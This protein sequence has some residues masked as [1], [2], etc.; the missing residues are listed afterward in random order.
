VETKRETEAEDKLTFCQ[1]NPSLSICHESIASGSC[2]SFTCNG[3]AI[4]CAIARD[5]L[6]RNCATLDPAASD[7]AIVVAAAAGASQPEGHPANA[8]SGVDLS[9]GFDKTDLLAG[10]CPADYTVATV[11]GVPVVMP[12][13]KLCAPAAMLGNLF[14]GLTA[15][16]CLGI[17]FKGS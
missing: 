13:S 8:A 9:A 3:D 2:A 1:E 10:A 4:M 5:Q 15:L 17:V 11:A 6:A 7:R 16:A 12:L 14:V